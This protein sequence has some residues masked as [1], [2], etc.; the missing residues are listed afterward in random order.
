MSVPLSTQQSAL[1]ALIPRDGSAI[2]N[3]MLREQLGWNEATYATVRDELVAAG[4]LEKGK[5]R[6]GSVRRASGAGLTPAVPTIP[7]VDSVGSQANR[8]EL[9][10]PDEVESVIP[11]LE[12]AR[13]AAADAADGKKAK[14]A[15]ATP[16]LVDLALRLRRRSPTVIANVREDLDISTQFVRV[17]ATGVG[18]VSHP[19]R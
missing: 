16:V 11:E 9:F 14:A 13:R 6:G 18:Y 17:S 2:G 12:R 1:L 10:A 4:I 19:L 3:T 5:G 7:L 8:M 15:G